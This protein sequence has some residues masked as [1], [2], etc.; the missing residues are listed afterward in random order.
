MAVN[1]AN[2]ATTPMIGHRFTVGAQMLYL[3]GVAMLPVAGS[4]IVQLPDATPS[5]SM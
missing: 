1:P 5:E 3:K 4:N 2:G